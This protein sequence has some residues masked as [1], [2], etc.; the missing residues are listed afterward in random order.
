MLSERV[1]ASSCVVA[2]DSCVGRTEMVVRHIP[3]ACGITTH[4]Y[5]LLYTPI[6]R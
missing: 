5:S 6:E 1:V 3:P 4:L 2:L